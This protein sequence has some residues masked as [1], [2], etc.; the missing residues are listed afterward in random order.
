MIERPDGQSW[1]SAIADAAKARAL[2]LPP[3]AARGMGGA[4]SAGVEGGRFITFKRR[5]VPM[6]RAKV[7]GVE[8][9]LWYEHDDLPVAVAAFREPSEPTPEDVSRALSIF[10]G[11]LID[12]WTSDEASTA[13]SRHPRAQPVQTPPA[14]S[15]EK[16]H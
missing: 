4:R 10:K 9:T 3:F 7:D 13:V 16:Q 11:W 5:L 8:W 14:V 15:G 1:L 2:S 6:E 12:Q